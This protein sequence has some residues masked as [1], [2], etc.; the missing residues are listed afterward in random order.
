MGLSSQGVGSCLNICQAG[1]TAQ[2]IGGGR[3]GTLANIQALIDSAH[4]CFLTGNAGDYQIAGHVDNDTLN[5]GGGWIWRRISA[6]G[7][8]RRFSA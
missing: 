6:G 7:L 8:R 1:P 4:D 2:A 5:G 3:R